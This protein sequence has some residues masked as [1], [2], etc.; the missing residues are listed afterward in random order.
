MRA[1]VR[2]CVWG[3]GDSFEQYVLHATVCAH[4]VI[5]VSKY[6]CELATVGGSR[7]AA[8]RWPRATQLLRQYATVAAL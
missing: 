2:V 1:R 4:A 6:L 8:V 7:L 3:G 5:C